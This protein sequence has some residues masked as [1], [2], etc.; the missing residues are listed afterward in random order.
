MQLE[1]S[2]CYGDEKE[3]IRSAAFSEWNHWKSAK[4][5]SFS[6]SKTQTF[7]ALVNYD[8]QHFQKFYAIFQKFLAKPLQIAFY[9]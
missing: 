5:D 2:T 9:I 3:V 4:F 1:G 6:P 7:P 8:S